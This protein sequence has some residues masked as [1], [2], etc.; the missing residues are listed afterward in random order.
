MRLK[1]IAGSAAAAAA[2]LATLGLERQRR[3]V[4]SRL[5]PPGQVA[6]I[7]GE[8]V[9]YTDCGSGPALLLIHGFGA[10]T[11]SWRLVTPSLASDRRVVALDLVGFGF[12][13]RWPLQPLSFAAHAARVA[14]LMDHL[15]IE[16]ASVVG[17]SM[18][19][20]IAQHLAATAPERVER[21][22]LLGSIDA[23]DMDSWRAAAHRGRWLA[24]AGGPGLR[25][26]AVVRWGVRRMLHQLTPDP[27][28][29][30][31]EMVRG[32]ADPLAIPGTARCLGR[33]LNDAAGD[34]LDQAT[35]T[36]PTLVLAGAEDTAVPPATGEAIAGRIQGARFRLLEGAGHFPPEERPGVFV[37]EVTAFLRE[38]AHARA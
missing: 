38:P 24:R 4:L 26:P 11:C 20:A 36:A 1:T 2:S 18:G 25:Y 27:G 23:G 13:D 10:N 21:L 30:T 35:I 14:R 28:V 37:D 19:G 33:L 5:A 22:I 12:S 8:K 32:Y 31:E 16:R 6:L 9:H 7:D 3:A 15:G 34:S 29:V 17:H